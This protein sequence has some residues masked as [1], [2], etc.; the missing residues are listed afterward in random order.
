MLIDTKNPKTIYVTQQFSGKTDE[1]K[2]FVIQATHNPIKG[3]KID[4]IF[5]EKKDG[6]IEEN[7]KIH[8]LFPQLISQK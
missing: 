1:G 8:E 6:T 3:W 5:W 4:L 2:E 7:N